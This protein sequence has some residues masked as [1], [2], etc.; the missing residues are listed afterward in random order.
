MARLT[1]YCYVGVSHYDQEACYF[2]KENGR[3]VD[4]GE[5]EVVGIWEKWKEKKLQLGCVVGEKR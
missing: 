4:L 5:G 3:G 1:A 2:L